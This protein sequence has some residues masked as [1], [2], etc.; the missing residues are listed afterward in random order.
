M[1]QQ[2]IH[3]NQYGFIQTRIIQDCLAWALEYLHMC[4]HSGKELIIIKLDF[5]KAFDKVEHHAM[6]S[7]MQH[8][9]FGSKW[10]SWMDLIFS[11]S[12]SSILLNGVPGKV[13]HCKRG[14]RQ[15]DPLSLL[16]YVLESNL[17]QSM[18]N[19]ARM[20]RI[21][22]LPIPLQ[23]SQDFP[24]LQYT[25]DTLITMEACPY[26]LLALKSIL[27]DFSHSTGLKI[28]YSKSMLVPI[29]LEVD[30]TTSLA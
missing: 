30:R 13:F 17:L 9:G 16:L 11:S 27:Q 24:V 8:K 1:I 29:N 6:K 10:L 19:N 15:G 7:I 22:N 23:H 20:Q 2:L 26:Q 14:V 3:K 25:D 21:L 28:N 4:H 18:I 5:E 12:T